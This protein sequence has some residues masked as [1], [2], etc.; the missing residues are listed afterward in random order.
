[1]PGI[2]EVQGDRVLV[3]PLLQDAADQFGTVVQ[4]E[5]RGHRSLAA[6]PLQDA[7]DPAPGQ[8]GVDLEREGFAGEDVDD[9]EHADLAPRGQGVLQKIQGPLFVGA[10]G[11]GWAAAPDAR[12][13]FPPLLAHAQAL[14]PVDP[15]DPLVVGHDPLP[16]PQRAEAP[17]AEAWTLGGQLAESTTHRLVASPTPLPVPDRGTRAAHHPTG[18][19][20]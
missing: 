5:P 8:A 10:R 4:H 1:M 17:I 11:G 14:L 16:P 9:A 19:P 3:R 6:E 2:D 20:L 18:A 12:R 15:F 7:N 13:G